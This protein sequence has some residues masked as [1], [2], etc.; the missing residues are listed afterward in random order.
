MFESARLKIDRAKHHIR[1][2]GETLD[3]YAKTARVE[4]DKNGSEAT[5]TIDHKA[6]PACSL[7]IGDIVHNLRAA[8]DHAFWELMGFDGGT[9]GRNTSLPI[10]P[11]GKRSDYEGT[12]KG[13]PTPRKDTKD[14]LVS[15]AAYPDGAGKILCDLHAFDI[16]DKHSLLV[17]SMG[18]A[19]LRDCVVVR[20]DGKRESWAS[21]DFGYRQTI[22]GSNGVAFIKPYNGGRFEIQNDT[23][24]A[25][26]IFFSQPDSLDLKPAIPTLDGFLSK[27]IGV[28][29]DME[30]MV[31]KR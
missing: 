10:H 25:L 7:V 24:A 19:A 31:L 29:D 21:A 8:L 3:G 1:E 5:V 20:P 13:I 11:G 22:V 4:F 26:N 9:Q 12:C 28:V 16:T 15:F 6:E 27:V 30:R 23:K 17:P 18:I 2:L 14:L